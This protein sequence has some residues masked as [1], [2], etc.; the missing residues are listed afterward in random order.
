MQPWVERPCHVAYLQ[1][2]S[3]FLTSTT[4]CGENLSYNFLGREPVMSARS[5]EAERRPKTMPKEGEGGFSQ[6]WYP[7][8]L[9]SEV[10]KGQ[11]IGCE[12]LDGRVVVYR[13]DD[14]QVRVQSA[15]CRH[16]GA[17]LSVGEVHGA[18]TETERRLMDDDNA[19]RLGRR[20]GQRVGVQR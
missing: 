1:A 15:Y 12:F 3:S 6:C 13:G 7:V 4:R 17:D 5:T 18:D 19:A 8:A 10:S 9:S 20:P 14:G 11:L 2:N 16:L